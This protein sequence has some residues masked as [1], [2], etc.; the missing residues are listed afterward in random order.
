MRH[1]RFSTELKP[2]DFFKKHLEKVGSSEK[3]I[4][5]S[6]SV[7][8]GASPAIP[9]SMTQFNGKFRIDWGDRKLGFD[10]VK[11]WFALGTAVSELWGD[12][13]AEIQRWGRF[14]RTGADFAKYE[15]LQIT[16]A[17]K[18]GDKTCVVIRGSLS[19]TGSTE[20][21]YFDQETGL[22]M[23]VA[24][25]T[26]STIG[27]IP[28]FMDYADYVEIQ[29]L[30]VPKKVTGPTADGKAAIVTVQSIKLETNPDEKLFVPP[31]PPGNRRL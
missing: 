2:A 14:F 19:P 22:L 10:G 8:E 7:I 28:T 30:K 11:T 21:L 12:P 31:T 1:R 6:G 24:T 23:R 18:V 13:A 4:V 9:F 29:G 25:I 17:D 3:A 5:M 26:R 16:G 15:R 27:S 20:E